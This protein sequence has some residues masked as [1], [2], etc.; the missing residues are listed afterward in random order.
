MVK[1]SDEPELDHSHFRFTLTALHDCRLAAAWPDVRVGTVQLCAGSS[2]GELCMC[3]AE[4]EVSAG[5]SPYYLAA[6]KA[7]H[8]R[9]TVGED[10]WCEVG[11]Q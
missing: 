1:R 8:A 10:A 11:I 7:S 6:Q 4:V 2:P 5:Q 3:T 9:H